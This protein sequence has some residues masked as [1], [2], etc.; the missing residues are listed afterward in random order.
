MKLNIT[1]IRKLVKGTII[2]ERKKKSMILIKG[3]LKILL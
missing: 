2:K 1:D 3:Q